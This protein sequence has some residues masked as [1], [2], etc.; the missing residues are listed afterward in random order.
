MRFLILL[1]LLV[2]ATCTRSS[3]SKTQTVDDSLTIVGRLV[4]NQGVGQG[5][6]QIY[7]GF[8]ST[9]IG[10]S[11]SQ[12]NF[13]INMTSTLRQEIANSYEISDHSSEF[14]LYFLNP[15]A[16]MAASTT[17]ISFQANGEINLGL[18]V[19]S[20]EGTYSGRVMSSGPGQELRPSPGI[21]V[22]L[23][24]LKVTTDQDG[25]FT[26]S[27]A[28]LGT[29]S[30]KVVNQ[31]AQGISVQHSKITVEPK[32]TTQ[33][34]SEN[35]SADPSK[36]TE[37][38][39]PVNNTV[40]IFNSTNPAGLL[41]AR[42]GQIS[43]NESIKPTTV[44][45]S[46]TS[47]KFRV[48]N[49]AGARFIRFHHT[50]VALESAP[51]KGPG[52]TSASIAEWKSIE[53]EIQYDFPS[54]GGQTLYYQF[55]DQN[56]EV[57]SDIF[58]VEVNVD[59][60][61]DS[62]GFTIEDGAESTKKP[63]IDLKIK[64]PK[65]AIAMRLAESLAGLASS[66]WQRAVDSYKYPFLTKVRDVPGSDLM[67][68]EIFMQFRD[69][70]GRE[71][72]MYRQQVM[73][74][75]FAGFDFIVGDGTGTVRARNLD[76][77]LTFPAEVT[78]I[79]ISE[80][81]ESLQKAFW[82]HPE[83]QM[84]YALAVRQDQS[85]GFFLLGGRREICIQA[86]AVGGIESPVRCQGFNVELFNH[87]EG[88][89]VVNDGL[90]IATSRL[91][92]V[93]IQIPE[94]AHEM[95]VFENGPD[96]T[97]ASDTV[98]LFPGAGLA[99]S[100]NAERAW[101]VPV[102]QLNYVFNTIGSRVLYLQ[103]RNVDGIV[104]SIYQQSVVILPVLEAYQNTSITLNSNSPVTMF[105][106]IGV[107]ILGLPQTATA[108]QVAVNAPPNV[109]NLGAWQA[110]QPYV[111]VPI[112]TPGPK[113]IY[114]I[115]RNSD[116]ELSPSFM[117]VIEYQPFPNESMSLVVN[118]GAPVTY[119]SQV[120]VQV[121]APPSASA[122]RYTCLDEALDT[123]IYQVFRP[124][125]E[126]SLGSAY[127]SN[128]RVRIQFRTANQIDESPFIESPLFEYKE[129]FPIHS[130]SVVIED[131]KALV[132][133]P[134]VKLRILA[135]NPPAK[136]MRISHVSKADLLSLPWDPYNSD[137]IYDLPA[138]DGDYTV[139]VQVKT[140]SGIESA[141]FSDSIQL[142]VP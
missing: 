8:L 70:F 57:S 66:P 91:V 46:L 62:D 100:T 95:R 72:R 89:F 126:C 93:N 77:R 135:P 73:L 27:K 31:T 121:Q 78:G 114:V 99:R 105:P 137:V 42:T 104:S 97:S 23:G 92:K 36:Q 74:D 141:V 21:Q 68:R 112:A 124:S 48:Y 128:K 35:N 129:A 82:Q 37:D 61:S 90:S 108:M 17:P 65:A 40:V 30:L 117:R 84:T 11:D 18:L 50:R 113:T 123:L 79:R 15:D 38:Q 71:S 26:F 118:N 125:F 86:N 7:A 4:S 133:N 5:N 24:P 47:L 22:S 2:Q 54:D 6:T 132:T 131:G 85:T 45:S 39:V 44:A 43:T 119:D 55:A 122:M 12:G 14:F 28:P 9:P 136:W 98:V 138:V 16:A 111:E 127:G 139:Y 88:Q 63:V 25:V 110:I 1:F 3:S 94:N 69:P 33:P 101:L 34:P 52:Q 20:E 41:I 83:R 32:K 19:S 53:S 59:V 115:F 102:N 58:K 29:A 13:S 10:T 67:V 134:Q 142:D 109:L 116:R 103:F 140:D 81:R 51:A 107:T 87:S 56:K 49:N 130:L 106:Y 75:I 64:L 80:N 120:L 76:I 96:T 60:F